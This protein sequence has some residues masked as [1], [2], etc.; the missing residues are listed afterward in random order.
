MSGV[1]GWRWQWENW[2]T[3]VEIVGVKHVF[4]TLGHV[5]GDL[6]QKEEK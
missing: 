3:L 2:L 5:E 6:A 1:A 4:P